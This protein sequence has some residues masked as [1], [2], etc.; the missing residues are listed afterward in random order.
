M[1]R[2]SRTFQD[3]FLAEVIAIGQQACVWMLS[4][5]VVALLSVQRGKRHFACWAK[6]QDCNC[7]PMLLSFNWKMI[8][9]V[10]LCCNN[11]LREIK[12][13]LRCSFHFLG[14]SIILRSFVREQ[15]L[16]FAAGTGRCRFVR[17]SRVRVE[18]VKQI[19]TESRYD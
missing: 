17:Y 10:E 2:S 12:M 18:H 19:Q 11:D 4:A 14:F 6:C 16:L 9:C 13:K 5:S 7:N 3:P 1:S 15:L 8:E